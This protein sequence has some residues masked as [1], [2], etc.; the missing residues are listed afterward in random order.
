MRYDNSFFIYYIN[1]PAF[2][3]DRGNAS[4]NVRHYF[5][6][7]LREYR[8]QENSL[9]I[10]Y[11]A[12]DIKKRLSAVNIQRSDKKASFFDYLKS[13]GILN[14]MQITRRNYQNS[15][16]PDNFFAI[17][18]GYRNVVKIVVFKQSEF[19]NLFDYFRVSWKLR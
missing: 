14:V 2:S 19:D 12:P 16:F 13:V 18:I 10:D 4:S 8:S 5:R 7:Y 6:V 17:F 15:I 11:P 9:G 3:R 1:S